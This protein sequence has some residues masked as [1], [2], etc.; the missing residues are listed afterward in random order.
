MSLAVAFESVT[1]LRGVVHDFWAFPEGRPLDLSYRPS[2]PPS[3]LITALREV[4]PD[5]EFTLLHPL[6]FSPLQ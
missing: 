1:G 5:E 6:P 2:G 4:A 3:E